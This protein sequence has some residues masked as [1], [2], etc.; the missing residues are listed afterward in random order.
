[1][2]RIPHLVDRVYLAMKASAVGAGGPGTVQVGDPQVALPAAVG[3]VGP[4]PQHEVGDD[5]VGVV[6]VVGAPLGLRYSLAAAT[7]TSRNRLDLLVLKMGARTGEPSSSNQC[8]SPPQLLRSV[9][10]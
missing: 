4:E 6:R 9:L 10:S 7:F 3:Q 1:M 8:L 5:L 2:E